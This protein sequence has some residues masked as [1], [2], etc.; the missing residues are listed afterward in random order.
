MLLPF[1]EKPDLDP[2]LSKKSDTDSDAKTYLILDPQHCPRMLK[3]KSTLKGEKLS[4]EDRFYLF[5]NDSFSGQLI[6]N[7][8]LSANGLF[9][10][11]HKYGN[12]QDSV[13]WIR[14]RLDPKL[15]AGSGSVIINFGSGSDELQFFVTKIA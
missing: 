9:S 3:T 12:G 6:E 15:F 8:A 2:K 5:I 14:I 1:L 13:L 7:S 4:V 11:G 10:T